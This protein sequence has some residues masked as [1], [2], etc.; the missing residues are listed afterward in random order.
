MRGVKTVFIHTSTQDTRWSILVVT[1]YADDTKLSL[2]LIFKGKQNGKI[3]TKEFPTF[4]DFSTSCEYFC[5]AN[6][7]MDEGA[8]PEWVE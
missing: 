7:W 5:Q 1:V 3:A 4:P 2:T 6:A 8:M